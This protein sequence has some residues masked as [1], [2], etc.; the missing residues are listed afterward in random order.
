M[1]GSVLVQPYPI[2]VVEQ[3]DLLSTL[4]LIKNQFLSW[5]IGQCENEN[6]ALLNI[7]EYEEFVGLIP[8]ISLF[9][10]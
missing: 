1:I 10:K 5:P 9:F 3:F 8:M 7:E 2:V 6:I 4:F